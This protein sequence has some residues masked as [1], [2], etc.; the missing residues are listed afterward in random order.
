MEDQKQQM[1]MQQKST[2]MLKPL[3][4]RS[5]EDQNLNEG[6]ARGHNCLLPIIDI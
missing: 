5:A 3:L 4:L 6:C 2:G 1:Y